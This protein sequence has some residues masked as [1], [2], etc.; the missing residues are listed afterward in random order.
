MITNNKVE[1]SL[2]LAGDCLLEIVLD[3]KG[4][5]FPKCT[6]CPENEPLYIKVK[7]F[8]YNSKFTINTSQQNVSEVVTLIVV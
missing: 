2:Q 3:I 7:A 4:T 8:L 6:K 1:L 5:L